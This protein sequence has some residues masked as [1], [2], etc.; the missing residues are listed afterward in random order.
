MP[1]NAPSEYSRSIIVRFSFLFLLFLNRI[2]KDDPLLVNS[3][4]IRAPNVSV[5]LRYNSVNITLAA[6]F[7]ISPIRLVIRD[8]KMV[9]FRNIFD[10]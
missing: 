2:N 5:L 4:P 6:Q 10:R 1:D 7:G 9:L 8:E 3:P